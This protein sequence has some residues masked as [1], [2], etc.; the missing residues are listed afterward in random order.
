MA[1]TMISTFEKSHCLLKSSVPLPPQLN[2]IKTGAISKLMI[3]TRQPIPIYTPQPCELIMDM[4]FQTWCVRH[5]FSISLANH[6]IMVFKS[7]GKW[8]G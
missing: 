5:K 4:A 8:L 3:Q 7:C 6:F 2:L 1:F